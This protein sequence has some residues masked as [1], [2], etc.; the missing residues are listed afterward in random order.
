M[1]AYKCLFILFYFGIFFPKNLHAQVN[2]F[3]GPFS[4]WTDCK[5]IYNAVGDGIHDDTKALQT[6]LDELGNSN[7]SPILFLPKGTYRIT[8]TLVMESRKGISIVGE[9]PLNTIIKWDGILSGTMFHLDGVAYSEYSRIT[10]DGN[11]KASVAVAHEWSQRKP[12]ANSGTQHCDEIFK[13][14]QI[15][16]KSGKNMDAEFSIRRCR[17]YDC[18]TVAISLQGWNAL[19]WWI[20]DCYFEDCTCGV[21][22][23]LPGNGAGNFCVYRSIF[24]N[25][26]MADISLGNSNFFSFRDNV[27]INSKCFLK[28]VQFSNTSP[29]TIQHN[30]IVS[31]NPSS[32]MDLFTKGNLLLLDND[33]ITPDSNKN[34][35]ISYEDEFKNSHPDLTFVGNRFSAKNNIINRITGK[36]IDFDN[37]YGVALSIP[38]NTSPTPF[39]KKVSYPIVEI[40]SN[41]SSDEIQLAIQNTVSKHRTMII[42]F[43]YGGYKI[44]KPIQIPGNASL[45]FTGDGLGSVL[46][47]TG[48][49]AG[50]VIH[51]NYPCKSSFR[52]ICINGNKKSNGIV[53]NEK[54]EE[55]NYVYANELLA[56]N[57]AKANILIDGF[58]KI[59]LLFENLQHNYCMK[60]NSVKYIGN[61]DNENKMMKIFGCASVGNSE[62]Y[63]IERNGKICVYDDWYENGNQSAFINLQH[64]GVFILN[65]GKIANT[66]DSKT[67]F[68]EL[69]NFNGRVFLSQIIFNEPNKFLLMNNSNSKTKLLFFGTLNWSDSTLNCYKI[70]S[71]TA[72]YSLRNN[73]YNIGV[74]SYSLNDAGNSDNGFVKEMLADLRANSV[75]PIID[76]KKKKSFC[77][78]NRVMIESGINNFSIK[79]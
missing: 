66:L 50:T 52:S 11:L 74:G 45:I 20:W 51:I 65:G 29:V 28:A 36:L 31:N 12:F 54:D 77:N 60:G 58:S 18:S 42:H 13:N 15:G 48:D 44:S 3:Y 53:L 6:A 33:F 22:N 71:D 76:N 75:T 41:M 5:K 37:Q 69:N 17:F 35:V 38:A 19:D 25:S 64:K 68:I 59:N 67:S 46:N 9:D 23:N 40:T 30:T 61:D 49:S 4:S 8:K 7:H 62:T 70:Q 63:H 79:Q 27:S 56:Y 72:L 43:N 39:E 47:W 14:L 34:F 2:E 16:L 32:V 1:A 26:K 10:W 24:K 57:G 78:I 73:R 21:A 55:G